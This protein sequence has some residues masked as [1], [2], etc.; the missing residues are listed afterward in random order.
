MVRYID[1]DDPRNC[2][3]CEKPYPAFHAILDGFKGVSTKPCD[4]LNRS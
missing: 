3:N 4:L 2:C 1:I